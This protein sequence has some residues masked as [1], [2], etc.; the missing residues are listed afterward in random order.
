MTSRGT[1]SPSSRAAATPGSTGCSTGADALA[2]ELGGVRGRVGDLSADELVTT[3][4]KL[5]EL[6]DLVGRAESYAGLWFSVDMQTPARG[7]LM[8][9]TEERATAIATKLLFFDLEWATVDDQ[10]AEQLL[11][12]P[13]L[14][15][16]R[17]HLRSLRRY[18]PHLLSEPEERIL[19]EKGQTGRSAWVR[20]FDEL[21]ADISVDLDGQT[22]SLEEGLSRLHH[23]D[24]ALRQ[25]AVG[26]RHRGARPGDQDPGLH[27]QHAGPRQVGG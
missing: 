8:Q 26:G 19:T 2:D 15:F 18:R 23:H 13:R 6:G 25:R 12:D 24:R 16:C 11:A 10:R 1:S 14:D 17:H 27:L 20:L 21:E 9:R 4:T 5:A 7:A 22:V 3:M